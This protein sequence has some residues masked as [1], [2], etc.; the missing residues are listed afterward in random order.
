M[1]VPSWK[2]N[3]STAGIVYL[4]L[5]L[6]GSL[7]TFTLAIYMFARGA[8][9]QVLVPCS[10]LLVLSV[11]KALP[12]NLTVIDKLLQSSAALAYT[13][14]HQH[15]A[16]KQRL[17]PRSYKRE[18]SARAPASIAIRLLIAVVMFWLI[19]SGWNMIIAA[20]QLIC[21]RRGPMLKLWQIEGTCV[22]QRAGTA[23]SMT[24]L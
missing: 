18:S 24:N 16:R 21:L 22:A 7:I 3:A 20:R 4:H 1:G 13:L 19:S 10:V 6:W 23:F 12:T 14:F 8:S 2:Y 5:M 11:S 15:S 17:E 9:D